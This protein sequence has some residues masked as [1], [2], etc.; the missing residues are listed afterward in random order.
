MTENPC[1]ARTEKMLDPSSLAQMLRISERHLT[2]LRHED[3]TFPAP[4]ML[5]SLPRWSPTTI[6]RW[7]EQADANHGIGPVD[8]PRASAG[9]ASPKAA[10]R[11]TKG[12][13]RV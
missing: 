1:F 12:A 5:G 8:P 6:R 13:A 11:R 4:R 3:P 9:T 2:D 7:V 10:E